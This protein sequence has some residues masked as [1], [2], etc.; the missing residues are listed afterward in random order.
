MGP[1]VVNGRTVRADDPPVNSGTPAAPSTAPSKSADPSYVDASKAFEK[2]SYERGPESSNSTDVT[3]S[4]KFVLTYPHSM[5]Q[6]D[7][8]QNRHVMRISIFTQNISKFNTA[9]DKGLLPTGDY[10]PIQQDNVDIRK[11]AIELTA[12]AG[13]KAASSMVSTVLSSAATAAMLKRGKAAANLLA[14]RK[15]ST[16][17]A[18]ASSAPD[19]LAGAIKAGSLISMSTINMAPT[20]AKETLGY[21]NLYMP[22]TLNFVNQQ[23]YDPVEM[24]DALGLAGRLSQAGGPFGGENLLRSATDLGW[25]GEKYTDLYMQKN[26][27]YALNPQLQVLYHGPR[28]R[29]FVFSFRF[30]PTSDVESNIVSTIIKALRFHAAP[31][32]TVFGEKKSY[33]SRYMTPPSQFEIDFMVKNEDGSSYAQNQ[34]IP[35]IGKCVLTN[36]DV[37][38]APSGRYAA[39]ETTNAPVEIAVQLSFTE[40]TVLTKD[41][42]MAGY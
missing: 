31:E 7:T 39:F 38:Y 8:A 14:S 34:H 11:G 5:S 42:I 30:T 18:V 24:T 41:D 9:Y 35:K 13:G 28:T 27:G 16:L 22:E 29:E 6:I 12:W 25:T 2:S 32:Y 1:N 26:L 10:S 36:V 33:N 19:M 17:A 21:I 3:V 20:T 4:K 15:L 37:N 40:T 23:D